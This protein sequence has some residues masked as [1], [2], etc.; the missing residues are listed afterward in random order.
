MRANVR[1]C[2]SACVCVCLNFVNFR[3]IWMNVFLWGRDFLYNF[4]LVILFCVAFAVA[5]CSDLLG[6]EM[7]LYIYYIHQNRRT[8]REREWRRPWAKQHG[9]WQ[10]VACY[11]TFVIT[12]SFFL[13][14]LMLVW[15]GFFFV[16]IVGVIVCSILH[17][18]SFLGALKC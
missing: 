2:A 15:G 9:Q 12:V 3:A 13:L 5:Y 1:A 11:C 6:N 8:E 4:L 14:L 17:T 7:H 10:F 18:I 16:V